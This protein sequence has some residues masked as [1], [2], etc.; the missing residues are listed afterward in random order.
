MKERENVKIMAKPYSGM[1]LRSLSVVVLV[2]ISMNGVVGLP[3][4]QAMFV[5]GDSLVD[6]GNNNFLNSLAKSNYVPYGV[7]FERGP[8][9][10]FSNGKTIIDFLGNNVNLH[11]WFIQVNIH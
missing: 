3:Q 7:D 8:S 11:I 5:F 4:F 6:D 2:I 9:G 1:V 10:R